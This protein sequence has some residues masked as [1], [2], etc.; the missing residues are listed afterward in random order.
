[1]IKNKVYF[2]IACSVVFFSSFSAFSQE[3]IISL[4]GKSGWPILSVKENIE[5]GKGRYGYDSLQ[6]KTDS[7]QVRSSTDLLLTFENNVVADNA[8]NYSLVSSNFVHTHKTLRG[9]SAGLS[10]G[11][12]GGIKLSGSPRSIFGK[13]GFTDSFTIDFWLYPSLVDTGET[14]FLWRSSRLVE[15]YPLLQ[16][17]TASFNKGKMVWSFRNVFANQKMVE[18]EIVLTSNT[19]IIPDVWA[20]HALEYNAKTATIEYR[21]NGVLEAI[22][23]T[24][25]DGKA[26]S[27]ALYIL[28]GKKAMVEIAGNFTGA[29]DDFRIE[30]FPP[31]T[32][33]LNLYHR[34]GGRF[35]SQPLDCAALGSEILSL[36]SVCQTPPHTAIQFFVRAADSFYDWTDSFPAW[37]PVSLDKPIDNV[38]GRYFQVAGELYTDGLGSKTPQITE[39]IVHYREKQLPIAPFE[40]L[41]ENRE[42]QV[43]L[44]W[45][46]GSD[47]SIDGFNV[48]IGEKPGEYL[49]KVIDVGMCN[50]YTVN[51]LENGKLY[52]FAVAAYS[53]QKDGKIVL[54]PLTK[55]VTG[56]PMRK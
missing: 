52:Y 12:K 10:R 29:L 36:S 46:I 49:L 24:T 13:E 38:E 26:S 34:E 2:F 43:A 14:I 9:K 32:A 37:V 44:S 18:N 45:K 31:D 11:L 25:E 7:A 20:H 54:G 16:A 50:S 22:A 40:L 15:D 47:P 8:A 53:K 6:L 42:E 21:V 35:E 27:S 41:A 17:I 3:K 56:R 48:Y 30:Q 4:G 33:N 39:L 23:N 1:M 55:E 28:L 5:I 19:S 51:K